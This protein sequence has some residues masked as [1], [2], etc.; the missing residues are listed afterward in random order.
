MLAYFASLAY[1]L[2]A[3]LITA[4]AGRRVRQRLVA[5]ALTAPLAALPVAVVAAVLTLAS[6]LV[7]PLVLAP[8]VLAA[9]AAGAGDSSGGGAVRS[10]WMLALGAFRRAAGL[11][12]VVEVMGVL[13]WLGLFI[14]LSPLAEGA[15]GHGAGHLGRHFG[16]LSALVFRASTARARGGSSCRESPASIGRM[17]P[18]ST[19]PPR[20]A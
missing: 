12:A 9:V 10:G 15:G 19:S 18:S 3:G 6:L 2:L 5:I 13:L 20:A 4:D 16:P 17:E 11:A 14:A 7:L 8:C 1:M